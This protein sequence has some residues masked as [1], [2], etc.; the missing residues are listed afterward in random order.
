MTLICFF[1]P[2]GSGKSALSKALAKKLD[3]GNFRVKLSWM[4]GTHTVA[5]VIARLLSKFAAFQG[6]DNPYYEITILRNCRRLWQSIEFASA[7]PVILLKFIVP[8]ALGFCILAERYVPDFI[9]WV[10]LTTSD[11]GYMKSIESRFLL[12]LSSK[13]HTKIYV[14]ASLE[15]LTRRRKEV[16]RD[17]IRGQLKLYDEIALAISAQKLD[18]SN[19][20]VNDSLKD[21]LSLL[22]IQ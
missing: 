15:E 1:G 7:L 11:Q 16:D 3:S 18:T 5:S 21:I 12:A 9:V 14:T 10:S 20:S 4:R 19:K 6:S 13:A 17:F 22:N 2:D 8:S